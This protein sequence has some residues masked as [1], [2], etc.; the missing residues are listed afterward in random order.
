MWRRVFAITLFS[1][2]PLQKISFLPQIFSLIITCGAQGKYCVLS[3]NF[4]LNKL[5]NS[6]TAK[7]NLDSFFATY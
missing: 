5:D 7:E 1:S 4:Q 2:I 6:K 3:A